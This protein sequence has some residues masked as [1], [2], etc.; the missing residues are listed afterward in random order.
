MKRT[1]LLLLSLTLCTLLL[2]A[3]G[4]EAPPA[5]TEPPHT[6]ISQ[7]ETKTEEAMPTYQQIS[8]E[9]AKRI[10]DENPEAIVLD[11]R[12]TSEFQEGHIPRA[13]LIEDF[14]IKEKAEKILTDKSATILVYCRSGRRSKLAAQTLAELGYE[15]VLEFGGILDWP[16]ETVTE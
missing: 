2:C 7:E 9:E 16:Y 15:N 5:G 10:M 1:F 8:P 4:K 12:T 13:I 11:V 14:A 3:C 6:K